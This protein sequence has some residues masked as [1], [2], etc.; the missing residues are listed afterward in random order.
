MLHLLT[1][2]NWTIDAPEVIKVWVLTWLYQP[3]CGQSGFWDASLSQLWFILWDGCVSEHLLGLVWTWVL[4][5][6]MGCRVLAQP[7]YS[8]GW[9]QPLV[10]AGLREDIKNNIHQYIYSSTV[11]A[12]SCLSG[13]HFKISK[14]VSV[15]YGLSPFQSVA[16]VIDL[17]AS[18]FAC[19]PLK[20]SRI[21]VPYCSVILLS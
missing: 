13:S 8:V 2:F 20:K 6:I 19:E 17:R 12:G 9:P 16:F 1:C 15:T 7:D 3:L 18:G 21:L 10:L 5:S 14:W 11:T 4:P